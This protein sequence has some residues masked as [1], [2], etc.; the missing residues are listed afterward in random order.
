MPAIRPKQD[1]VPLSEFRANI[2]ELLKQAQ[3]TGR[4]III[5]QHGR[6][7]GVLLSA[8]EYEKVAEEIDLL[9]ALLRGQSDI[10]AGRTVPHGKVMAELDATVRRPAKRQTLRKKDKKST[11]RKAA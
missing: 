3:I 10:V 11:A 2:T 6:G 5:T 7:A 1:L 8:M 4:P 9:R